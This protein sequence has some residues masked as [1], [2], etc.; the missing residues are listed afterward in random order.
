MDYS[1]NFCS[2]KHLE[3]TLFLGAP[4]RCN[5]LR[6]RLVTAFAET[7]PEFYLCGY[8]KSKIY[9]DKLQTLAQLKTNIECEIATITKSFFE[10]VMENGEKFRPSQLD[11]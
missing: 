4:N 3:K 2:Q 11:K 8:L 6:F 1:S 7:L 5:P 9:I 10:K